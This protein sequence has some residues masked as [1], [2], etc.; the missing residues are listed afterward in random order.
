MHI[1]PVKYTSNKEMKIKLLSEMERNVGKLNLKS[2]I[3][4]I[5]Q[6]SC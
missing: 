2:K 6:L 1:L 5:F 4:I 3:D